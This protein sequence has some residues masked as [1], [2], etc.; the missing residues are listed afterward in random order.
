MKIEILS[1]VES[2]TVRG[3]GGNFEARSQQAAVFND[4]VKYPVL[5]T[6][7]LQEG[8]KEYP[9]GIYTLTGEFGAGEYGRGV[10]VKKYNLIPVGK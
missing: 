8:E 4:G 7:P 5:F 6:L 1:G 9:V 2:R 10:I 3:R